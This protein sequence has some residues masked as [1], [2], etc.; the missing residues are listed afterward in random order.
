MCRDLIHAAAHG[1]DV[2]VFI[3]VCVPAV[4]LRASAAGGA[5][6][7]TQHDQG[8]GGESEI[9]LAVAIEIDGGGG[10]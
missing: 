9:G 2:A 3:H 6:T 8:T 1:V 7:V 5:V 10:S 4:L